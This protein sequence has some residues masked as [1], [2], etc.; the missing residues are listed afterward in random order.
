MFQDVKILIEP[1][2]I[3]F[4][5]V[6]KFPASQVDYILDLTVSISRFVVMM[7]FSEKIYTKRK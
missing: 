3:S 7:L 4:A 6:P 1:G 2:S 5:K